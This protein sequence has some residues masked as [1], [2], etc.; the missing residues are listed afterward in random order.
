MEKKLKQFK[1]HAV[2]SSIEIT[3]GM[4]LITL[5]RFLHINIYWTIL[6]GILLA[7]GFYRILFKMSSI[8]SEAYPDGTVI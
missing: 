4:I 8:L 2:L 1:L 6:G 5:H 7:I 3:I